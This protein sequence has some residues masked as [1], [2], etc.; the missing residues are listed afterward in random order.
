MPQDF[1]PLSVDELT[2]KG[3]SK[4]DALRSIRSKIRQ[5]IKPLTPPKPDRQLPHN[6]LHKETG[7]WL[8]LG[9]G[10]GGQKHAGRW[11]QIVGFLI[12][13]SHSSNKYFSV[14]HNL[15]S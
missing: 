6:P 11:Y 5:A 8:Y 2:L 3:F 12:S 4:R 10:P 14:V 7:P 1:G 9:I 13:T 15:R